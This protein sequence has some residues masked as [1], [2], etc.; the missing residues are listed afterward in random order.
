M[1]V[2]KHNL[3]FMPPM[4]FLNKPFVPMLVTNLNISDLASICGVEKAAVTAIL[5]AISSRIGQVLSE[6]DQIEI[7]LGEL[8]KLSVEDSVVTFKPEFIGYNMNKSS[9]K[10]SV[11]RLFEMKELKTNMNF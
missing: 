9:G 8:G 6:E 3:E 5:Q 4:G 10:L 7:D 1:F 2:A 11:R